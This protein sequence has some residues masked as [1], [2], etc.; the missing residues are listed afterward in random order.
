MADNR[1]PL[2]VRCAGVEKR[3]HPEQQQVFYAMHDL[4]SQVFAY[5]EYTPRPTVYASQQYTLLPDEYI[6]RRDDDGG[7]GWV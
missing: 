4:L 1:R 2:A 6:Q 7:F 5:S 3:K